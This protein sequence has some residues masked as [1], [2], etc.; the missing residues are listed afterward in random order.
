[1]S[2]DLNAPQ[3]FAKWKFEGGQLVRTMVQPN[4]DA[5]LERVQRMR[6]EDPLR[7]L[8]WGQWVLCVPELHWLR[9][10]QRYPDLNAPH[11]L[12]RTQAWMRLMNSPEGDQYRVRERNRARIQ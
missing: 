7:T 3:L 6:L 1:M 4:E 2:K 11:G 9:L 5:I 8:E 12:T 10:K